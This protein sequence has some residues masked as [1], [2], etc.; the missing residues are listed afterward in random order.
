MST[1]EQNAIVS[2]N[3]LPSAG[4]HRLSVDQYHRMIETGVLSEDDQV[5]LIDG[6]ILEMS[7]IGTEH[8]YVVQQL[9]QLLWGPTFG[10]WVVFPQL[11]VTLATSEPEP[12]ISVA[13]G[14]NENYRHRRPGPGDILLIIEVADTSLEKD[15]LVKSPAYAAAGVPEYWIVNL[16]DRQVEVRRAPSLVEA[17]ITNYK[18]EEIVPETGIL[19]IALDGQRVCQIAVADIL[20]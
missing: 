17:G 14:T 7:P 3:F 18:S 12:D 2:W 13:R 5:E 4:F 20:P 11:P 15:R 8:C 19:T 1:H 9:T 16:L 10:K 6:L